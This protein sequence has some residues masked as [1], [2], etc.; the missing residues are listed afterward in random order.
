[1]ACVANRIVAGPLAVLGSIGVITDI[2]N[3]YDRLTK[4][5]IVFN[6]VTA[7]KYKRSLTPTKKTT[8]EDLAKTKEDLE[9]ILKLFK[10][11]VHRNRPQ[12]D[13][14]A[15]AT[16]ETWF[17]PEAVAVKLCDDIG[18]I[19]DVL[20]AEVDVGKDV[21]FVTTDKAKE[22]GLQ[23]LLDTGSSAL[24]DEVG[25]NVR[26]GFADRVGGA[27][28]RDDSDAYML[29]YQEDRKFY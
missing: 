16:G 13:I 12:L 17:G 27:V 15:V 29:R 8:P 25:R 3:V 26:R 7:G 23:A 4:E 24:V 14:D 19:D 11:F 5:G 21:F 9:D 28:S 2:P 6:T 18:T 22:N 20:I 1:M 10:G